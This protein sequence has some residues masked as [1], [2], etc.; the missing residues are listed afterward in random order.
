LQQ[1]RFNGFTT[2]M[3]FVEKEQTVQKTGCGCDPALSDAQLNEFVRVW[4]PSYVL[5]MA[6][7]AAADT[8][9]QCGINITNA[10][11]SIDLGTTCTA[12][13]YSQLGTCYIQAKS[14]E[15]GADFA[16]QL[17]VEKC[18]ATTMPFIELNCVG[19]DCGILFAACS[20][21]ADCK[22]GGMSCM[23]I[24]D[25]TDQCGMQS[26]VAQ[27]QF[28]FNAAPSA[29]TATTAT[30]LS[31][32]Q[33]GTGVPM[34][35]TTGCT[36]GGVTYGEGFSYFIDSADPMRTK[37]VTSVNDITSCTVMLC[38]SGT[39]VSS[40]AVA[41]SCLDALTTQLAATGSQCAWAGSRVPNARWPLG[42]SNTC[43][44]A[45][46]TPGPG[47]LSAYGVDVTQI[48]P[49][50]I[51]QTR[52]VSSTNDTAGTAYVYDEVDYDT[53][54]LGCTGSDGKVRSGDFLMRQV[55]TFMRRLSDTAA[56][57]AVVTPTDAG[58]FGLCMPGTGYQLMSTDPAQNNNNNG[59][60][61]NINNGPAPAWEKSF[62]PSLANQETAAA[63]FET[64]L[65]IPCSLDN[66]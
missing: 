42:P 43:N 8:L 47:G 38:T 4:D 60:I 20:T 51:G 37:N 14:G 27:A 18:Q 28:G 5:N 2:L 15:A 52:L 17:R 58:L 11:P 61:G 23:Q 56:G 6:R 55:K 63:F 62:S 3:N 10:G 13:T 16:L 26:C 44:W 40:S 48:A 30:T 32:C 33:S 41:Q 66:V 1:F 54:P 35:A 65:G 50:Y 36:L 45:Q 49:F 24:T 53:N 22:Q 25:T 21:D 7:G 29:G 39:F 57:R 12:M 31:A 34:P 19:A 9:N 46:I 64:T 59:Q